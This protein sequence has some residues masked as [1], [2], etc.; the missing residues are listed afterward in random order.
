VLSKEARPGTERV[1]TGGR[2][3]LD[4][5]RGIPPL[6]DEAKWALGR[7]PDRTYIHGSFIL[8]MPT[9][10]DHGRPA[11][12]VVKVFD[13]QPQSAGHSEARDECD[14]TE[15]VV[16]TTPAGRKQIKFQIAGE[17]GAVRQIELEEVTE[18]AGKT[19]LKRLLRLDREASGRLIDVV[20]AL[21]HIPVDGTEDTVR[22]EVVPDHVVPV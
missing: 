17:A 21:E 20:K 11:R 12:Y 7:F 6:D 4:F 19:T 22:L 3:Q 1:E 5:R 18:M 15:E 16:Y 8:N 14:W 13:E 10:R 9:S 2:E